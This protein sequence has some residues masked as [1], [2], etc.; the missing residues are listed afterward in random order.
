MLAWLMIIVGVV[1]LDQLTKWLTVINLDLGESF[2]VIEGFFNFKYVRNTGA[3]FSMFDDPD[4][5]WIFMTISTVAIIAM[6]VFLWISRKGDKLLCVAMSFIIGGGIG[7]MIDRVLLGYVIDFLD[8]IIWRTSAG[9]PIH[10]ATFNIADSFVCVGVGLFALYVILDE[11]K[12]S[13]QL[14]AQKLASQVSEIEVE[15][16]TEQAEENIPESSKISNDE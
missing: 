2:A 4:E 5:R 15:E 10:F 14:K 16:E 8:F 6:S 11:I 9:Y 13:K 1:F 12:T 3:A 7:N